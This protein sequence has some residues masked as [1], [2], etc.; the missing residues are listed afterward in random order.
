MMQD[1]VSSSILILVIVLVNPMHKLSLGLN[2]SLYK[3]YEQISAGDDIAIV[4]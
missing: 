4:S 2:E 1:L 3:K